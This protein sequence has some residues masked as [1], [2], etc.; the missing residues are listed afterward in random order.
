MP[1]NYACDQL[2]AG[3][4][5][6]EPVMSNCRALI[7][8]GKQLTD[9]DIATRRERF[10][11]LTVR[12]AESAI[13]NRVEFQDDHSARKVAATVQQ[14]TVEY[15]TTL[16]KSV[17]IGDPLT[18]EAFGDIE[19]QARLVMTYMKTEPSSTVLLAPCGDAAS[20]LFAHTGNVLYLSLRLAHVALDY[21]IRERLRQTV[22]RELEHGLVSDL[23]PLATGALLMDLGMVPL[24]HSLESRSQLEARDRQTLED[25]PRVVADMLPPSASAIVRM[26]VRT[27]HENMDGSGYPAGLS[28]EKLHVFTRVLR[29]ADAFDAAT[30]TRV[31]KSAKSPAKVLWEMTAGPYRR[32]YDDQLTKHLLALIQPFPIG[33]RVGLSDGRGAVVC[34]YNRRSPFRPVV[35]ICFDESGELLDEEAI[36]PAV[37]LAEDE[38]LR[39]AS[40]GEEKLTFLDQIPDP[41]VEPTKP[42][43]VGDELYDAAFP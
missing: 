22:A 35:A 31:Y 16:M 14:R 32:F 26:L 21:V 36:E 41:E 40:C 42:A 3:M 38:Q 17:R 12:I 33:T 25:H 29:I 7:A 4:R 18:T 11:A 5:L 13:D 27:H 2:Q 15:L 8:R 37:N 39:I 23:A 10:P 28:G 43:P 1:I 30:A 6:Y 9:H 24:S 20:Y 34:K 19:R